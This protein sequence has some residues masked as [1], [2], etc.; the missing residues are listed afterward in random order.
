MWVC[1]CALCM[2]TSA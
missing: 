2:G 1:V